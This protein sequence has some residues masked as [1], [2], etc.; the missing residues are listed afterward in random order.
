MK[1]DIR[2]N[3]D[4][5][6]YYAE[7][8]LNVWGVLPE[9][10]A[11]ENVI[12]DMRALLAYLDACENGSGRVVLGVAKIER[13]IRLKVSWADLKVLDLTDTYADERDASVCSSEHQPPIL[14]DVENVRSHVGGRTADLE[15]NLKTLADGG[16]Q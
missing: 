13:G 11:R 14:R 8:A 3:L 2:P 6:R 9:D 10:M 5:I 12:A 16:A 4:Q 7:S 15:V 1:I